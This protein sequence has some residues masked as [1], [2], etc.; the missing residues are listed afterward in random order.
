MTYKTN[1]STKKIK[2]LVLFFV[3]SAYCKYNDF[4]T[5]KFGNAL[6]FWLYKLNNVPNIHFQFININFLIVP[7]VW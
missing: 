7:Y 2:L 1:G 5:K 4:W 3:S 6:L